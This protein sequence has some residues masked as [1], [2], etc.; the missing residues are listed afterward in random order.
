MGVDQGEVNAAKGILW[1]NER[2]DVTVKQRLNPALGGSVITPTSVIA[3]DK[4]LIILNRASLRFRTDYEVIPYRQISS[5]RLEH[6]I[7]SSTV[8][9]RVQGYD[10]DKGLL[11][12]GKQEGE[13][14]GLQN[15][16]AQELADY[17]NKKLE[18]MEDVAEGEVSG[19]NDSGIGAYS[20]CG[21]CGAKNP[22]GS[23]FCGK[24][25]AKLAD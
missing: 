7:V 9:I 8:F 16:E 1:P 18:A 13:I 4:R 14:D 25:G 10:Q 3:T 22:S 17:I 23:K 19:Q 11:K 20:Y 5:V 21:K 15:K 2:V 12:N 6:G 24:C